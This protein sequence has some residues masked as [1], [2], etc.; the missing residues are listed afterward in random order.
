MACRRIGPLFDRFVYIRFSIWLLP[1]GTSSLVLF[2]LFVLDSVRVV[3]LPVRG[4][5][6][7]R[8]S[9]LEEFI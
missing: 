7:C 5:K 2:P 8:R 1:G 4:V 6:D 9:L 3:P